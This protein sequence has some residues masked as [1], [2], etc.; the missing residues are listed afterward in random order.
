MANN[1]DT[2][3]RVYNE[4]NGYGPKNET[5]KYA[6]AIDMSIKFSGVNE[7]FEI[8]VKIKSKVKGASSFV[9]NGPILNQAFARSRCHDGNAVYRCIHQVLR[10]SPY[11]VKEQERVSSRLHLTHEQDWED[12]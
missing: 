10:N 11:R 9:A 1:D 12:T 6:K 5:M 4:L 8:N 3:S 7:R 2:Q